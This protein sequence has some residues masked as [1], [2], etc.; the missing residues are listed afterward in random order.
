LEDGGLVSPTPDGA[1][2]ADG[3]ETRVGEINAGLDALADR[4]EELKDYG[5]G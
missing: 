5:S 3:V 1:V 2:P 4:V